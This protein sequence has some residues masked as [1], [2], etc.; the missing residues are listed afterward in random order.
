MNA[1]LSLLLGSGVVAIT[2]AVTALVLLVQRDLAPSGGT[3]GALAGGGKWFLGAALGIGVI[4]FT[5]KLGIVLT[6]A[7]FPDQTI[8]PLIPTPEER[9]APSWQPVWF[10][11]QSPHPVFQ[12]LPAVVPSPPENPTT[13]AKVALGERL[14]HET[15]L[16]RDR[17]VS[18]ASCHDLT[19]GAGTD[20]RS[21]AIGIT[22]VAGSRNAPTVWNAA[23]QTRLFWDGRAGSLEEQ[24]MGPPLN[25]DEMGMP[26]FAAIEER[27][28]SDPSYSDGF[29][30]AFGERRP[31][32]MTLI[33]QAIAAYER[34][35]IS[36]DSPYDR[37]VAGET[38][39]L[40]AAQ[41]RG[42]WLFQSIGCINCHSGPNFSG[43][44]AVGP[45]NPYAP[46]LA[47]RSDYAR[48]HGLDRDKGRAQPGARDGIWRIPSLR[49]VALTAPYFH[50]GSVTDLAEAVRVMATAQLG[51]EISDSPARRRT[52]IWSASRG[53]FEAADRLVL[54]G[55]DVNDIVTFLNALSGETLVK[56]MAERRAGMP[57]TEGR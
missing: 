16:S 14:F 6:L 25:P 1:D 34:T 37:F 51:A 57:Y 4:A 35:L 7:S 10:D 12:T 30:A 46:L 52:P 43:A 45:R 49:N 22:G 33:V 9:N 39:A 50:N 3:G 32:S 31:V 29:A 54:D 19:G 17:S 11:T 41:K 38:E 56:R 21:T 40:T 44:S 13:P 55:Q 27:I 47:S 26:S 18:C 28:A 23:F 8:A 36:A 20:N 42:M 53:M 5:L 15:A 48:R 2:V 24:A